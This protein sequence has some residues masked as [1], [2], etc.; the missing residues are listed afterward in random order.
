MKSQMTLNCYGVCL[1]VATKA[2]LIAV[3][4]VQC[5]KL[6]SNISHEL[7]RQISHDQLGS[8][9]YGVAFHVETIV[10]SDYRE[11][12][13]KLFT[14]KGELL[15]TIDRGRTTFKPLG[16]TV[17]PDGHIYVCDG[18]NHCVCVFD[19][20]GKSLFSFG[21]HGSG[22]ECFDWPRDLCFASDGLLYITDVDNSRICVYDKDGKFISKFPTTCKPTCIDATDCGHLIV[23]SCLSHQVMIYT[24]GGEL[25]HVF[26]ECDCGINRGQFS[27]PCGVFVDSDSLIYIADLHNLT[28][29]VFQLSVVLL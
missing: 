9:L 19:V 2:D 24:T 21:S 26:G 22:G 23:S 20:K 1:S 28:I 16:V 10:V 5:I 13:L 6:Y 15:H 7:L 18:A 17:S 3:C 27:G 25:V 8:D 12:N 11:H 4:V 29:E 14:L